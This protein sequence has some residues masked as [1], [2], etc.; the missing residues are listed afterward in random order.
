MTAIPFISPFISHPAGTRKIGVL[1]LML[2]AILLAGCA[3]IAP[4]SDDVGSEAVQS[5]SVRVYR[6]AIDLDGR[7]SVQYQRNGEDESI[8]GSF[9]WQQSAQRS[10]VAI[11]S[12]L[13]QILATIDVEPGNATLTQSGHAPRSAPDV[14]EL[15]AQAL[16]WPLPVSGLRTWLQGFAVDANGKPFAATPADTRVT[17]GDSWRIQY[18]TWDESDPAHIHPKRIDLERQTEQAGKVA[19]RIVID[20]WQTQ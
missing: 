16:G 8:H 7:L 9:T 4:Q 3:G 17:T 11:L 19:I 15:A 5:A 18:V 10:T 12:P 6:D 1:A 2:S 14:D 20:R 13:G